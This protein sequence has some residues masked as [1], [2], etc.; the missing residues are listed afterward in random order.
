[1]PEVP[2]GYHAPRGHAH[3]PT[4]QPPPRALAN[5]CT[6]KSVRYEEY[7]PSPDLKQW[8]T[9]HWVFAVPPHGT[10]S[11]VYTARLRAVILVGPSLDAFT[12][13]VL[14][15]DEFLGVRLEPGVTGPLLGLHAPDLRSVVTP[16]A[17]CL[18][19]LAAR[20]DG[21][22]ASSC[23]PEETRAIF[24][25]AIRALTPQPPDLP[26]IQ[27]ARALIGSGGT[28]PVRSLASAADLSERQFRR[29]FQTATGLSP[30]EFA[31]VRRVLAAVVQMLAEPEDGLAPVAAD[32][33]DADQSHLTR[34][35]V[36]V[37]GGPPT[38]VTAR[39]RKIDHRNVW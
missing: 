25:S 9:C 30:K 8:L 34:E 26:I 18:P 11:L 35:V 38:S 24:E 15:G 10:V 27:A 14:P 37:F 3:P 36:T 13:E 12:T 17:L 33:G 2:S 28:L 1:M 39:L 23:S 22:L 5:S 21:P 32:S 29:R 31:R 4:R 20:L 19:A 7:A 6:L 16:L